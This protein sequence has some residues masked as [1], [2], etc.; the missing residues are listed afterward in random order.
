[1]PKPVLSDSLFNADDV[2]TAILSAANLQIANNQLGVTDISSLVTLASDM[3]VASSAMQAY[4]F[5]GFVFISAG[6]YHAGDMSDGDNIATISDSNYYPNQNTVMVTS[7][8]G[9]DLSNNLLV[10]T[11]GNIVISL[12]VNQAHANYNIRFNGFYRT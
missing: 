9:P 7:G 5:M 6:L 10:K 4:H 11:D 12:P 8:D 3:N 2:A 1:M